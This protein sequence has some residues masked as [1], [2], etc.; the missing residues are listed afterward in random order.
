MARGS[1]AHPRPDDLQRHGFCRLSG[2]AGARRLPSPSGR[3]FPRR[4]GTHHRL[5]PAL[6]PFAL[7]GKFRL[8]PADPAA[9]LFL[10][11]RAGRNLRC[12]SGDRRARVAQAPD[13]TD[14]PRPRRLC[15]AAGLRPGVGWRKSAD[16]HGL[17]QGSAARSGSGSA[18]WLWRLWRGP[19]RFIRR[20]PVQPDRPRLCLRHRPCARRNRKRLGLV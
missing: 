19:A 12:R 18:L 4:R 7:R 16:L 1:A 9:V 8:R 10:P 20:N 3:A 2:L 13:H 6:L 14:R 17:A 11:D 15:V 5:R